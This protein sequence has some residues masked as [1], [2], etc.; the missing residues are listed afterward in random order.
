MAW[1][2]ERTEHKKE[3]GLHREIPRPLSPSHFDLRSNDHLGISRDRVLQE[4]IRE[5]LALGNSFGSSGSRL[6]SGNSEAIMELEQ[7]MLAHYKDESGLLFSS[8]YQANVGIIA[9]LGA[10]RDVTLLYDEKV[11]A[12]MRDGIRMALS[13]SIPFAHNDLEDLEKKLSKV[14]GAAFILTEGLFS[15]DGDIPPICPMLELAERFEA[16]LVLDEAHS[17]GVYGPE[18]KGLAV[19]KG[20]EDRVLARLFPFGK[21]YVQQ[22]A[23]VAGPHELRDFLIDHARSFIYSTAPSFP[24]LSALRTTFHYV[25]HL[26]KARKALFEKAEHFQKKATE[27]GLP[28]LSEAKGPVQGV[29]VEGNEAVQRIDRELLDQGYAVKGVRKPTVPEGSERI[30]SMVHADTPDEVI[31]DVLGIIAARL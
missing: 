30:R 7:E 15:M 11:H 28:F 5:A 19:E 31:S 9:A 22:G 1:L 20:V 26:H 13:R 10:Y 27:F 25:P 6:I 12:S 29:F 23:F 3:E 4:R 18:G 14:E 21:A 17:N 16:G 2:R 24:A 8:G